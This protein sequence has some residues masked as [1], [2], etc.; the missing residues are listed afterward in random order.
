ML[1]QSNN[2]LLFEVRW[3][4]FRLLLN[5]INIVLLEI[6]NFLIKIEIFSSTINKA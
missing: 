1:P 2:N 4:M 6:S 5:I 3:S